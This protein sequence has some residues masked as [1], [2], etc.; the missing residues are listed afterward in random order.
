MNIPILKTGN[1]KVN[2]F[3]NELAPIVVN[4]YNRRLKKG[5]KVL[6]PSTVLAMAACESGWN[7]EAATLFGIK[8]DGVELNT[9]EY[10]EGSYVDI[11][12]SFVKYPNTTA[13]VI[14]LY[15]LVQWNHYDK[16]TSANNYIDECNNLQE[17]G[18]ATSP[19]Y[20]ETLI[21]ITNDFDLLQFNIVF[22]D[23]EKVQENIGDT[24]ETIY[25]VKKGDNLWNIVK[26]FY[27]LDESET[28]EKVEEVARNNNIDNPDLI[29]EGME[30]NL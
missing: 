10:I 26:D 16:A 13:A 17:A 21:N 5:E 11:K 9:Q 4:E 25:I 15:D 27:N 19:T 28:A 18:Y 20:A 7:L 23:N 24:Q 30:I 14:G 6:F 3:I 12:D 1:I 22:D 8:G 2:N 29:Y